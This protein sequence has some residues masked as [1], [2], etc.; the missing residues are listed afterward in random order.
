MQP[1]I[2]EKTR[3]PKMA[4]TIKGVPQE[5][6]KDHVLTALATSLR[7]VE[8]EI[9]RLS[10]DIQHAQTQMDSAKRS[11]IVAVEQKQAFEQAIRE[12]T[13]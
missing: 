10:T 4:K 5:A 8:Q 1:K 12:R 3:R 2:N 7:R 13:V 9:A 6:P 11:L